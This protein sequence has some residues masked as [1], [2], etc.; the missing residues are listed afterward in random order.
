MLK[1]AAMD[2][3]VDALHQGFLRG[4]RARGG[5]VVR[6]AGVQALSRSAGEWRAVTGAGEFF[7]PCLVNAAGAWRT[8]CVRC[9]AQPPAGKPGTGL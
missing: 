9:D 4:I 1:P 8:E 5:Q 2:I 3:D 6:S 7:A